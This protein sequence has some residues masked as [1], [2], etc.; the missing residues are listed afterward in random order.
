MITNYKLEYNDDS[1]QFWKEPNEFEPTHFDAEETK[2]RH[3]FAYV[4]FSAGARNCIGQKFA[5]NQMKVVLSKILR[6]YKFVGHVHEVEN[7]GLP[8][9]VMKM[10]DGCVVRVE[11]RDNY[12][13]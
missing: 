5:M 1:F 8:E 12:V 2:A 9:L 13:R 6:R 7:R 10:N 11:M 4:P 3:P